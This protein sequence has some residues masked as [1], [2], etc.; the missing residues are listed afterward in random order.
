MALAVDVALFRLNA[1]PLPALLAVDNVA[2]EA[3][4]VVFV[5]AM[6]ELLTA[7]DAT[8]AN[9]ITAIAIRDFFMIVLLNSQ[10]PEN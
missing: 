1:L 2:E 9:A 8:P 3:L 6:L 5:A 7:A 10:F 4:D